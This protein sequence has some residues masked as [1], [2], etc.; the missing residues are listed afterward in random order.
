MTNMLTGRTT[1]NKVVHVPL[2][3]SNSPVFDGDSAKLDAAAHT[4]RIFPVVIEEAHTW[5][6]TGFLHSK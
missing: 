5:F 2:V 6:L 3:A 1:S 4:G